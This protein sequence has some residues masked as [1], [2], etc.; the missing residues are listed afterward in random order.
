MKILSN[1]FGLPDTERMSKELEQYLKQKREEEILI[2][3]N[4]D[5]WFNNTLKALCKELDLWKKIIPHVKQ[6]A[7]VIAYKNEQYIEYMI[8]IFINTTENKKQKLWIDKGE[9]EKWITVK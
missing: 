9:I 5:S 3:K 7:L 6:D 2:K 1:D 8:E 4:L